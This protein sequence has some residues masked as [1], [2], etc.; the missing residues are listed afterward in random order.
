MRLLRL[1][2]LVALALAAPALTAQDAGGPNGQIAAESDAVLDAD[3]AVRIREIL[4]E[5]GGYDDVTVQVSEGIVRLR[6]TATSLTDIEALDALVGRVEGVVAIRNQ[7]TETTDIGRRLNPALERFRGRLDQFVTSLPLV[8]IAGAAF[9]LIAFVGH[10]LSNR[11]RLWQRIAPNAFIASL[12]AQVVMIVFVVGGV[13]VAL[14]VLNASALLGTILGAAGI[15]GLAVGFAVKDTVEN[16]IASIMLSIRQPFRP[17]D[18]IELNGDEGKVIRMTSRATILLSFDGNQIRIPNAIVF[19][20]RIVNYTL[21]PE[22]RFKFSLW[23]ATD[24]DLALALTTAQDVVKGLPFTLAVPASDAWIEGVT[25]R[26][27]E[28]V[29]VGWIDQRGTSLLRAKGEA[30]RLVKLALA[31]AGIGLYDT[32]LTVRLPGE[33]Q[34]PA[35]AAPAES[36][37]VKEVGEITQTALDD[38]AAAERDKAETQDFLTEDARAE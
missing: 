33:D 15:V 24:S 22:R 13:V 26:G 35:P 27:V 21:N 12:Y 36:R 8:L 7:V 37:E 17:N 20:S 10:L 2:L 19:K 3:I 6:G 31:E 14:D 5:L 25:D 30:L 29:T 28:I 11:V 16:Y 18:V 23:V 38:I 9:A 4:A 32:S 34:A 1:L